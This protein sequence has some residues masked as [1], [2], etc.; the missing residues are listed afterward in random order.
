MG[1]CYSRVNKGQ[2]KESDFYQTPYSL[3]EQ[4]FENEVFH[5]TCS[6]LEPACGEG[7][8]VK[9]LRKHFH[10]SRVRYYDKKWDDTSLRYDFLAEHRKWDYIITNPPYS[11][12]NEFIIKCCE[13]AEYKFALLLPLNYLQGQ[14]RYDKIYKKQYIGDHFIL[15]R[16][17]VFTR[18]P[19]LSES[20]RE[21]GKYETGMQA[22]A[23]FVWRKDCYHY[24]KPQICWLDSKK[25][26]LKKG[27]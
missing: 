15:S 3:T 26:I 20:I 22:L 24:E 2:R 1:K 12:A 7:A 11:L 14:Y 21:D 25:Y 16:V 4:L 13:C 5:Q 8:I 27:E 10:T 19:M 23:W 18:M 6:V 9:V 17:Y